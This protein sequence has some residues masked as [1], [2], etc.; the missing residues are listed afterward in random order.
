V[1]QYQNQCV[2]SMMY[3]INCFV[4][5][6][7]D[8]KII[9]PLLKG[10]F[11]S[12]RQHLPTI[13][14]TSFFVLLLLEVSNAINW[15]MWA[16]TAPLWA[17]F[18]L[19]FIAFVSSWAWK[20][21]DKLTASTWGDTTTHRYDEVA[22]YQNQETQVVESH[23]EPQKEQYHFS[24]NATLKQAEESYAPVE[25]DATPLY[26]Q[27]N[28]SEDEKASQLRAAAFAQRAVDMRLNRESEEWV[29]QLTPDLDEYSR[30][31]ADAP[32]N[33]ES[34]LEGKVEVSQNP[35]GDTDATANADQTFVTVQDTNEDNVTEVS[36]E[37]MSPE[38]IPVVEP[39][40]DATS[41]TETPQEVP[42]VAADHAPSNLDVL[43]EM[44]Q[45]Q[46]P[47]AKQE[48]P[49]STPK[50]KPYPKPRPPKNRPKR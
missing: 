14:I 41:T 1:L 49:K 20:A 33:E 21:V 34:H 27:D 31:P 17:P 22:D 7:T 24:E 30:P 43:D 44:F 8:T 40:E 45:D 5:K 3:N 10:D 26:D 19:L 9:T 2:L 48:T 28:L 46:A 42:E 39:S 16:I 11:M 15:S 4:T 32:E 35:D 29:T 13:F 50:P 37:K 38:E 18:L 47:E 36:V 25:E 6:T 23:Y 12:I